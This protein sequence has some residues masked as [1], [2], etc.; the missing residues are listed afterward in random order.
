MFS[1]IIKSHIFF[2]RDLACNPGWD[3]RKLTVNLGYVVVFASYS[4]FL[5]HS[6]LASHDLA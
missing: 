6:Q 4:S 3:V 5:H 2:V 1:C